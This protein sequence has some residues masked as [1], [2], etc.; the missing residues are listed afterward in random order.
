MKK[1]LVTGVNGLVGNAIATLLVEKYH[2]IGVG[3][4]KTCGIGLSVDYH[5]LD[6]SCLE[7]THTLFS[8]LRPDVIVHCAAAIDEDNWAPELIDTNVRGTAN[9]ID[10]ACHCGV[11]NFIYISSLPIIGIPQ[12]CPITETHPVYPRSTYHL[13]KYFGEIL[14]KS[15][16]DK[17]KIKI[18][19]LPSPIGVGMPNNKILTVFIN[20]CLYHEDITLLGKGGRIQNYINVKDVAKSVECAITYES[21]TGVFNVAFPRS[22]SNLELVNLC[23][24]VL[25][26]NSNIIFSG[27]DLEEEMKWVYSTDK[28]AQMLDFTAEYSLEQT[29]KDIALKIQ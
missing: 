21:V 11:R 7:K 9:I 26:S 23:K 28:A 18:L 6:I 27:V 2:V 20:K 4:N 19:R 10:S 15:V 16:A 13:T 17:M 1:V 22:Y 25:H 24:S 8:Q 12:E 5:V 3:R 29:I 14:L